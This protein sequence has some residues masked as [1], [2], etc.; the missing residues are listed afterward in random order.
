MP[1]EA[2]AKDGGKAQALVEDSATREP[3]ETSQRSAS[4]R[5]G[6]LPD[7]GSKLPFAALNTFSTGR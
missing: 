4:A 7:A 2:M 5:T 1:T 6:A 3:C